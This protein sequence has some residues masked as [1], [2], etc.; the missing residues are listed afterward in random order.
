MTFDRSPAPASR[1][2]E[3]GL[4]LALPLW[5]AGWTVMR[6]GGHRGPGLGWTVAHGVWIVAILL[7]GGG[8]VALYRRGPR[9]GGGRALASAALGMS[10]VGAAALVGQLGCDLVVGL[11]SA[12]RTA[13]S[14]AYDRV[15]AVPGVQ[16]ALFQVGPAL[17]FAGLLV[18][19]VLAF[20]TGRA[21]SQ[22]VA[23]V[24]VGIIAQVAGKPL[25][26]WWRVVEG[27]G[28]VCL[29]WALASIARISPTTATT[30][31]TV[32]ATTAGRSS[33]VSTARTTGA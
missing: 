27:L 18:L 20:R 23:L 26:G 6:L 17:L 10:L 9:E 29:W 32:T 2:T 33:T 16:L 24:V 5:L 8:C 13:M 21:S 11:R 28:G 15:F 14:D 30:S 22:A 1:L 3:P 19:V 7:L 31:A 4:R 12:D 25:P